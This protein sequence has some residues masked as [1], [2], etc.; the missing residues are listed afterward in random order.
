MPFRVCYVCFSI[1]TLWEQHMVLWWNVMENDRL[2]E[3]ALPPIS[4][5]M[6]SCNRYNQCHLKPAASRETRAACRRT[7][8]LFRCFKW[9]FYFKYRSFLLKPVYTLL[10]RNNNKYLQYFNHLLKYLEKINVFL[11]FLSF[12]QLY[13]QVN[14]LNRSWI[15]IIK[16]PII[17]T[18]L[19]GK[20]IDM[21]IS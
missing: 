10:H 13:C 4:W 15:R 5:I 9:E 14:K 16:D 19:N 6:Y 3:D 1:N 21:T 17:S 8:C 20:K 7:D 12:S 11:K 18:F 2:F